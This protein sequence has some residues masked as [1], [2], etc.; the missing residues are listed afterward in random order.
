MSQHKT[1][2]TLSPNKTVYSESRQDRGYFESRQDRR[3]FESTQNRRS[4]DQAVATEEGATVVD[5]E[6]SLCGNKTDGGLSPIKTEG[7]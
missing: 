2:A 1:E 5:P 7:I 3:Y 6:G 4:F